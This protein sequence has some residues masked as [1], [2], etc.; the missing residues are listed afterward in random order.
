M[1]DVD[2]S[3]ASVFDE[4]RGTHDSL[5]VRRVFGDAY[6]LDGVTIIPVGRVVG[7]GGVGGGED[8]TGGEDGKG[9]GAGYGLGA[10]AIGVY[11]VRGNEVV[12]KPAIDATRLARGGQV[13]AGIIAV[14]VTL[15]LLRRSR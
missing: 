8:G 4:I 10:H 2:T 3:A 13:L 15:V 7:G 6:E 14:C 5:T 9:F 12:W 11:E 1:T